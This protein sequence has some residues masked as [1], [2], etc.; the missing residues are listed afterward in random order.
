MSRHLERGFAL[1]ELK[2]FD[3]AACEFAKASVA[4][5]GEHD[6]IGH[7][8][9]CL[10]AV[11]AGLLAEA[12]RHLTQAQRMMADHP[13]V[14]LAAASLAMRRQRYGQARAFVRSALR[15]EP[16][17]ADL[18]SLASLVESVAGNS[19][20]AIALAERALAIEPAHVEAL[21]TA[22]FSAWRLEDRN[23]FALYL[24]RLRQAAPLAALPETILAS[25]ALFDDRLDLAREH[26]A[27]A[28]RLEPENWA[29]HEL[30][31]RC[32]ALGH[33]LYRFCQG[34]AGPWRAPVWLRILACFTPM[35]LLIGI[36]SALNIQTPRWLN[37][38]CLPFVPF[39]LALSVLL[40]W[41]SWWILVRAF[42]DRVAR[43]I[44]GVVKA[45][46]VIP[47]VLA[48]T[49]ALSQAVM[50]ASGGTVGV[51]GLALL[52]LLL[53]CFWQLGTHRG[54]LRLFTPD[55]QAWIVAGA[56]SAGLL[57][58][59]SKNT[60]ASAWPGILLWGLNL[61]ALGVTFLLMPKSPPVSS[62][63]KRSA[64]A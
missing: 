57:A 63:S 46:H 61:A 32:E 16:N 55:R 38:L 25:D 11:E 23:A 1:V 9:L 44:L 17:D 64:V 45:Y 47:A 56:F 15:H 3:D 27:K 41:P 50:V 20:E 33:P 14:H 29:S 54:D 52:S 40:G 37:A 19:T 2:R 35:L 22:L 30:R 49:L 43:K 34:Y 24:G 18:L 6:L 59:V 8:A 31:I 53:F 26:T 4:T 42:R 60:L 5:T 39:A 48:A 58:Q 13:V 21:S 7:A 36:G 51:G 12:A 62:L 10:L 28:L